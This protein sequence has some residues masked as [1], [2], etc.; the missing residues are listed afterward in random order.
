[1]P[2]Q[3]KQRQI[4]YGLLG[5]LPPKDRPI[6]AAVVEQGECDGYILEKLVLEVRQFLGMDEAP[7]EAVAE[8]A[9]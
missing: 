4:L 3:D 1:M 6:D 7:E 2:E 8:K 9:E 5:D